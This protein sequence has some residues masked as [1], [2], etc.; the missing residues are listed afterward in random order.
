MKERTTRII[1]PFW[2]RHQVQFKNIEGVWVNYGDPVDSA[3]AA[4]EKEARCQRGE[5]P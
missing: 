4:A 2:G 5:A 3:A 1:R